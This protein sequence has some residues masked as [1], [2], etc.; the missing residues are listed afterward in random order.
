MSNARVINAK[1]ESLKKICSFDTKETN[2][3]PAFRS[4]GHKL[5]PKELRDLLDKELPHK[6]D[7]HFTI[8]NNDVSFNR[9]AF[10]D[11]RE[12]NIVSHIDGVLQDYE[13]GELLYFIAIENEDQVQIDHIEEGAEVDYDS[14][15]YAGVCELI[16]HKRQGHEAILGDIDLGKNS[17][18]VRYVKVTRSYPVNSPKGSESSSKTVLSP[19]KITVFNTSY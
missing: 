14:N 11:E 6:I 16:L 1:P 5:S 4:I 18:I 2:Y 8:V 13:T 15:G 3:P 10:K 7:H 12:G 17:V 19:K 9:I